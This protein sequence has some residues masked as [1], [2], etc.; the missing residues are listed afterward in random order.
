MINV[1]KELKRACNSSETIR[2][3]EFI[4]FNNNTIPFQIPHLLELTD[5]DIKGN[6]SANAYTENTF[7]GTFNMKMLEFEAENSID[8]KGKEFDYYKEVNGEEFKIG[9]FI[10]TEVKDSDTFENVVVTAYD[11]AL[12]FATKYKSD[13]NFKSSGVTFKQYINEICTKCGVTLKNE[14]LIGEN[15]IIQESPEGT[16]V[17]FGNAI[18]YG[19]GFQGTFATITPDNELEFILENETS[20]ESER[21]ITTEN[22]EYVLTE[23]GSLIST[24]EFEIIQDYTELDDKRDT[25]PI[26]CVLVAIDEDSIDFGAIVKDEALISKYGENWL[27]IIGNP[28][29]RSTQKCQEVAP[30]ILNNVKGF[31]YTAFES[32][33]TFKPYLTLGDVVR[34]KRSDG[35]L[36]KTNILR[37]TTEYDDIT[38][39]APSIINASVEYE[40]I[41]PDNKLNDALINI[42]KAKAQIVLKVDSNGNVAEAR[43]DANADDGST[44]S[45]KADNINFNGKTF[46]LTTENLAITSTNFTLDK[47]G[48]LTC[49]NAN[50]SGT[51][52]SSNGTIAGWNLDSEKLSYGQYFLNKNGYARIYT[53]A[54]LVIIRNYLLGN[55]DLDSNDIAYY[56]M[57]GDGQVTSYE[58]QQLRQ[59]II[60]R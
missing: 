51:I 1:S 40:P 48:N 55:I 21:I 36:V 17:Q 24:E 29:I 54:D 56:D 22:G 58:I 18:A 30:L 9:R 11:Y 34:I 28:L 4:R 47:N 50:V 5:I 23:S 31:G 33:Y 14:H 25:R 57:N 41:T 37:I 8:F 27:R 52:T 43:L 20:G 38:L 19:A 45:I 15:V 60:G 26:T 16:D 44:F 59:K 7:F 49:N 6:L 32:K 42:D 46:N 2:Y 10:V 13:L 53:Y 35:A 39:Q 12:K 3:R